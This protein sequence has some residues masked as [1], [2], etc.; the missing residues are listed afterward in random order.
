MP[1]RHDLG[2]CSVFSLFRQGSWLLV[3]LLLPAGCPRVDGGGGDDDDTTGENPPTC[4]DGMLLDGDECV[5]EACGVGTWGDLPVDDATVHVDASAGDGG[6]GSAAAP[7][8]TISA[9]LDAAAAQ[10]ASTVAVARGE[11]AENLVIDEHH[12]GIRLAGRCLDLVVIDGSSDPDSPAILLEGF[13]GTEQFAVSGFTVTGAQWV[14]IIA[15]IGTAEL[16]DLLV[17]DNRPMGIDV[18]NNGPELHLQDV[19]VRDSGPAATGQ[20]GYGVNVESGAKLTATSCLFENNVNAGIISWGNGSEMHLVEVVSRG[21]Q[22]T[23]NNQGGGGITVQQG[24]SLLAEACVVEGNTETGVAAFE[25]GTEVQLVDCEILDTVPNGLGHHGYGLYVVNG[26]VLEASSSLVQGNAGAGAVAAMSG[27]TLDLDGVE[28]RDTIAND[29]GE[30]GRGIWLFGEAIAEVT[31]CTIANNGEVGVFA[32]EPGTEVHLDDVVVRDT[33]LNDEELGGYGLVVGLGALATVQDSTFEDNGDGGIWVMMQDAHAVI[34]G[35]EIRGTGSTL[36]SGYGYGLMLDEGGSAEVTNSVIEGSI[37]GGV[38]A[39]DAGTEV[40]LTDVQVRETQRGTE[41]TVS[42]G[43]ASNQSAIV[44]ATNLVVSHSEGPGL[45]SAEGTLQCMGCTLSDNSFAGATLMSGGHLELDDTT[46]EGTVPDANEGGG[47]GVFATDQ[48]GYP[49]SL[50]LTNSTIAEHPLAAVW[51]LGQGSYRVED[52]EL[53][54]GAGFE[55]QPGTSI[56][57]NAVFATGGV[58]AWDDPEGLWLQGNEFHDSAGSG[59]L[60]HGASATLAGN[61]YSGNTVDL[62]QQACDG[63]EVPEGVQEAPQQE[64]CPQ[65]DELVYPLRFHMFLIEGSPDDWID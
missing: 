48:Y 24:A 38:V 32:G 21:N 2:W 59:V 62:I 50:V 8:A 58:T 55:I 54:G 30:N 51:L 63:V 44:T 4:D 27:A 6:D 10:G 26:A 5:P 43:V 19:E 46:I 17:V 18:Y 11:Y 3:L 16:S 22:P 56:H 9:G 40:S 28:I 52:N 35:V 60:L 36:A 49:G 57:G 41:A 47:V 13:W 61:S 29:D 1:A 53:C 33:Q 45:Y 12:D 31:S 15:H 64:L 25:P 14:G 65:Y 7:F 42:A 39:W 23:L 37:G 34:D 20:W